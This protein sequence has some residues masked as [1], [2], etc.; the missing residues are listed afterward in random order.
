M[1]L[2]AG[3]DEVK[4]ELF[5]PMGLELWSIGRPASRCGILA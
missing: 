1:G 3:L 5:I 4:G 2:R